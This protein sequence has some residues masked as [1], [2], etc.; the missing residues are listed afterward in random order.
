MLRSPFVAAGLLV[1]ALGPLR[2]QSAV[3]GTIRGDSTNRP[4]VGAEVL[5]EPGARSTRANSSGDF[6][7]G[8]LP[9]GRYTL[10]FRSIGFRPVRAEAI[11]SGQDTL[12]LDVELV[13]TAQQLAPLSVTAAAPRLSGKME[14]FERRRKLGLGRFFTRAEL[15]Q[16][17][18]GPFSNVLRQAGN[19][20]LVPLPYSCNG[21]FAVA[22]GR[23]AFV[24]IPDAMQ[25]GRQPITNACYLDI[26][27]DGARFWHWG[28]SPP[29]EIDQY[30]VRDI[31]ALEVYRG[32]SEMPVEFAATGFGCG[33]I[34]IW[35]RTGES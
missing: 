34:S 23:A 22:T 8:A 24:K 13:R 10:T 14:E 33:A 15:A 4:V 30:S 5:V 17:E 26:Y 35:T 18:I 19:V 2:A 12:E 16:W 6:V 11:L 28:E 20:R 3:R 7:I 32:H 27:L 9:A 21:G 1:L 25:C 29:P 31:Q